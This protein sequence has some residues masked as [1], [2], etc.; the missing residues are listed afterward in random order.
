[1]RIYI[2]DYV[3][4][5]PRYFAFIAA[6]DFRKLSDD[7]PFEWEQSRLEELGNR[8]RWGLGSALD[9]ILREIR[10]PITIV[11]LTALAALIVSITF[12]PATTLG[13]AAKV[14]PFV[15]KVKPWMVKL[16]LYIVTQVTTVGIGLRG[17]GRLQ[18][19]PLY[20]AWKRGELEP[21]YIGDQRR[22]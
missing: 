11:A 15:L 5:F 13:T 20:E 8:L 1:M 17:Y 2:R 21:V 16:A 18:N 14:A 19:A 9:L 4:D 3:G 12:Y 7:Q 10:N 6:K 22:T